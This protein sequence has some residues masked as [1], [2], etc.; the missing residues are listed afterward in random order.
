LVLL[1]DEQR[2]IAALTVLD[3]A[4]CDW[5]IAVIVGGRWSDGGN[6]YDDDW[7]AHNGCHRRTLLLGVVVGGSEDRWREWVDRATLARLDE[8]AVLLRASARA[9]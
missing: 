1:A 3:L 4:S 5:E 9:V 8:A 2:V 6:W 7:R